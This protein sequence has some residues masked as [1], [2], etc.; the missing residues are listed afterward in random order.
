MRILRKLGKELRQK[1]GYDQQENALQRK[2]QMK[3]TDT[4]TIQLRFI[5]Q[6]AEYKLDTDT[7]P[8]A[9][10]KKWPHQ[11]KFKRFKL[12]NIEQKVKEKKK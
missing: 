1:V 7:V 11:I 2:S 6:Q 9:T 12:E 4:E 5:K 10:K 3:F 8:K